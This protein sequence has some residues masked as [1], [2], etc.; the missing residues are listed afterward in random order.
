M[1]TLHHECLGDPKNTSLIFLH[2]IAGS[3]ASWTAPFRALSQHY[4]LIFIDSLGFGLS[5]KPRLSYATED[6]LAALNH[7]LG[8]LAANHGIKDAILVGHSM[9]AILAA[10]WTQHWPMRFDEQT[11]VQLK[12]T[13]L[14][15]L[16]VY[17]NEAE[18][19]LRV[20]SVS[21]FNRWMALETPL[22]RITCWLMCH[23]RRW[24][25]P[26]MPYFLR[27]VPPQVAKDSLRHTWWSYS[28]SLREVVLT[29]Q[30]P[31][32][33]NRLHAQQKNLHFIHGECDQLAPLGGLTHVLDAMN[34]EGSPHWALQTL[35][36]GHD[37]VFTKADQCAEWIRCWVVQNT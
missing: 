2:G 12:G 18:A 10:H 4:H 34:N 36:A 33:L 11:S 27:D 26:A 1:F 24:L 6:H 17:Q 37:I 23:T 9:G 19:R 8:T 22:A 21:L 7:T 31:G 35:D 30:Q 15:S 16:P 20:G 32:L 29:G 5:P 14:L 13:V 3:S 28:G 25:M